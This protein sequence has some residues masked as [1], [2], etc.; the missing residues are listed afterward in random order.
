MNPFMCG[1]ARVLFISYLWLFSAS[2]MSVQKDGDIAM[3]QSE[4][5]IGQRLSQQLYFTSG[6]N[7]LLSPTGIQAL[8]CLLRNGANGQTRVEIEA[9][10]GQEDGCAES[11]GYSEQLTGDSA[12]Q[13]MSEENGWI[14]SNGI[15]HRSSIVIKD[16]YRKWLSHQSNVMLGKLDTSK[17]IE[18]ANQ[19]VRNQSRS[20]I[21]SILDDNAKNAQLIVANTNYF[22]GRWKKKFNEHQT[23]PFPFY[24]EKGQS[25][26]PMMRIQS[27]FRFVES[28]DHQAIALDY[29]DET[30]TSI[31]ILPGRQ[32]GLTDTL[33]HIPSIMADLLISSEPRQGVFQL[34]RFAI[35]SESPLK[36]ILQ[37][38]GINR[39]FQFGGAELGNMI[40]NEAAVFVDEIQ[41]KSVIDVNEIGTEAASLTTAT[42]LGSLPEP[43]SQY[44]M[45][46]DRPFV[47]MVVHIPTGSVRYLCIVRNLE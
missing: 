47:F 38:Q 25:S 19:W 1:I 9:F 18:D 40:D 11:E 5:H 16:S 24:G 13:P 30:Y 22:M 23:R 15:F 37:Q 44:E 8:L 43:P 3:K 28:P 35:E 27:Q 31:V 10:L 14:S 32:T 12:T 20:K 41:H 7:I 39:L 46:V 6:D 36:S 2:A 29:E 26:V 42:L 33:K 45:L 4:Y 17:D 34:P 21:K